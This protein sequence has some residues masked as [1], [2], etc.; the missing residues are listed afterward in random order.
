MLFL[1]QSRHSVLFKQ[2]MQ[3]KCFVWSKFLVQIKSFVQ[4]WFYAVQVHALNKLLK[5]M[6]ARCW[7]V[8]KS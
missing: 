4:S 7:Q 1:L 8:Q 2:F 3:L 5:E 6:R